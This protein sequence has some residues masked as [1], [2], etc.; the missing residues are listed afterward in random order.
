M[1]KVK[2]NTKKKRSN[3][4]QKV[5]T[6]NRGAMTIRIFELSYTEVVND[7][8]GYRQ[9]LL[10]YYKL[11]PEVF[12]AIFGLGFHWNDKRVIKKDKNLIIPK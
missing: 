8:Y 1:S 2:E 9:Y 7:L 4:S 3:I 12:P 5:V 6:S 11:N 10:S